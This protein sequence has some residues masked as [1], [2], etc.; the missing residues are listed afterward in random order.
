MSNVKKMN[1]SDVGDGILFVD[2]EML[3]IAELIRNNRCKN[4]PTDSSYFPRNEDIRN[5]N[6]KK[7][8][9]RKKLAY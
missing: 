4:T 6:I 5:K 1:V 2:A 7:E 8:K 9:E 3:L